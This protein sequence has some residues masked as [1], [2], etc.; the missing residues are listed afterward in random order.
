[1]NEQSMSVA[2]INWIIQVV[3]AAA[4]GVFA[5]LAANN[6]FDALCYIY[7]P[8]RCLWGDERELFAI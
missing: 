2:R 3:L 6:D 4:L 1:M 7:Y 5:L 8:R